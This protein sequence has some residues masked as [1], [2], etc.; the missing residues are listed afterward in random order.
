MELK[1]SNYARNPVHIVVDHDVHSRPSAS[2]T[3]AN[4]RPICLDS[5]ITGDAKLKLTGLAP[6]EIEV[7]VRKPAN[8]RVETFN[9]KVEGQEWTLDV[10]YLVKDVGRHE[11]TITGVKDA[12]G[13]LWDIRDGDVLSTTVEVVESARI[14]PVS[15]VRDLCVGDTLDFLLQGKAPWTV[16]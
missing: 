7:S 5:R 16:E 12:S 13:C 15:N 10:P 11:I 8:S 14:V 1:D 4:P 3:K 6:F 9:I 2:F